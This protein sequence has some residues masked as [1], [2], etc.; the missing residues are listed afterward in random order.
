MEF[1]TKGR[2]RMITGIIICVYAH[3][4]LQSK[5]QLFLMDSLVEHC[6]RRRKYKLYYQEVN[7]S[8]VF[9]NKVEIISSHKILLYFQFEV[10]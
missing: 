2:M 4:L 6:L 9:D 7:I 1:Y 3:L 5:K 10:L 8:R